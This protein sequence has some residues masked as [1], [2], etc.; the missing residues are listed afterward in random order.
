[1][2]YCPNC[3]IQIRGKKVRCPLCQRE[4]MDAE[5]KT[6]EED[7]QD[8]YDD[9]PFV[10]LPNPKVSFLFL[11]RVVT[12]ICISLEI[13]LGAAQIISGS[14]G[15]FFAAMLFILI[16]WAD[17]QVAVFYRSNLIRMLTTQAYIIMAACLLIAHFTGTG[18]WAVSWVVPFMFLLL[19]VVT[20]AAARAQQMELHEYILYP[21]FDFL[22]SLLQI[23]PIALGLNPVIAPAVICI[24]IMLILVC[25]LIIFRGK[26]LREAAEKYLHL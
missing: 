23:I 20:F 25:S 6:A 26:M 10:H 15:W 11:I 19:I 2:Q 21:A 12:F 14:S 1:M 17:F 22:M 7:G 9:D 5:Y 16:G 8:V 13:L 3:K 4:L 18:S 24:A